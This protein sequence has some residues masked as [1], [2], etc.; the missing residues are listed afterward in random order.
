MGSLDGKVAFITGAARGQGRSHALRLAAEGADI[1]AVDL[2]ADFD[3]VNYPQG[4]KAEFDE[5]VRQVEALG[6]AVV[7]SVADVR[8]R[9]DLE[10]VVA[11]G[12]ERFGRL[13]VV[14]A[15][16][17]IYPGQGGTRCEAFVDATDVDLIGVMNTVAVSLPHL[18]SGASIIV[19][20][21]TA[22]MID[23]ATDKLGP[24]GSGY[25]WAKR[26]IASYVEVLALQLAPQMIRLNAVHPTNCNTPLLH[27]ID[28]YKAF[29]PDLERPTRDDVIDAFPAMHA[30]P[31]PYIEPEDVSSIVAFLASE[32]S[33]YMT[34][35]NLRVD[36][37]AM[38]K[39]APV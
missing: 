28:V 27:N 16:A 29:R 18:Q 1:I 19:T 34:G 9:P 31:V 24:G 4:T 32:Q 10:S 33:R 5:T 38:L 25:S 30:M 37:G 8:V 35:L 17:G 2:C 7:G 21:S 3:T 22:G 13:D 39:P 20:G 26:T 12:M 6:R 15:N 23:G 11:A 14:V 36:A